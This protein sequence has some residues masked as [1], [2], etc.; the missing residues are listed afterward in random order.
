MA[1]DFSQSGWYNMGRSVT[2]SRIDDMKNI[3]GEYVTDVNLS[4][5]D[6]EKLLEHRFPR[7]VTSYR[8]FP[9]PFSL[10]SSKEL[11]IDRQ[12]N[13]FKI[14]VFY[15]PDQNIVTKVSITC[16]TCSV[17]PTDMSDLQI[18]RDA[19]MSTSDKLSWI[20]GMMGLFTGFSVIS[21]LE[22]LYWL[23]F[24]VLIHKKNSVAPTPQSDESEEDPKQNV[25]NKQKLRNMKALVGR[26]RRTRTWTKVHR[27][28]RY[29]NSGLF[30]DALCNDFEKQDV[31]SENKQ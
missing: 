15:Q 19:K 6:Q 16:V 3:S 24:K 29:K 20:G 21:G 5:L 25:D 2:R 10:Y 28:W 9:Q 22:I 31:S 7:P 18:T 23:W 12:K 4:L 13:I 14:A 27:A 17:K 11:L 26:G 8:D 30:F 1:Y